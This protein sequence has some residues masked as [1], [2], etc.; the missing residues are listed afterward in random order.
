MLAS[1][2]KIV[3]LAALAGT[4]LASLA[5]KLV[6]AALAKECS[7][8]S[9]KIRSLA[10]LDR[11]PRRLLT[12]PLQ[13]NVLPQL[14]WL[15]INLDPIMQKLLKPSWVK[16]VITCWNSKVDDELVCGLADGF[17][18]SDLRLW[19]GV[20]PSTK[21]IARTSRRLNKSMV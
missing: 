3:V 10:S 5:K 21:I 12:L 2:A 18:G 17:G 4:M 6:L 9:P 13:H 19:S 8:R 20:F 15:P 11:S 1:L 7:L 14:P 16:D